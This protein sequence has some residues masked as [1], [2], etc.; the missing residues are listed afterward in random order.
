MAKLFLKYKD[1]IADEKRMRLAKPDA[2]Y[3]H[4]LPCERGFEVTDEVM[5]GPWGAIFDE[6]ENRLHAQKG[7]MAAII[8]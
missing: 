2:K 5:D 6:A 4:C 8:P 1:W 7:V 3:M